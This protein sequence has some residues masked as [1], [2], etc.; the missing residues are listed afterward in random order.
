MRY[1]NCFAQ[2]RTLVHKLFLCSKHGPTALAEDKAG[3]QSNSILDPSGWRIS[4]ASIRAGLENTCLLG[5]SQFLTSMEAE[6]LGL[7]KAMIMLDGGCFLFIF[8]TDCFTFTISFPWTS[9]LYYCIAKPLTLP[10]NMFQPTPKNL[11]K[12]WYIPYR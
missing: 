2:R 7:S 9:L 4:D 8:I 12:H 11:L 10:W 3:I 6:R 1:R 5:R